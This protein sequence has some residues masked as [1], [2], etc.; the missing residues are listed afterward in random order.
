ME[1]R[2]DKPFD[3]A[4]FDLNLVRLLVAVYET[5]SVSRAALRLGITQP[6]ISYGLGRLRRQVGDALFIRSAS[7]MAP[8]PVAQALYR[9]FREALTAVESAI[10]GTLHFDFRSSTRTFRVAMSDVG[11]ICLVPPLLDH[12]AQVAPGVTLEV[13]Q[14]PVKDLL[15]EMASGR[16]DAAVGNLPVVHPSARSELLFPERYVCLL[17]SQ[18]PRIQGERL[19]LDQFLAE[20]HVVVASPF[21]VH[22][23]VDELLAERGARRRAALRIPHFTILPAII[24]HS[25]LLVTLPSALGEVFRGFAPVR[26]LELPVE[27]PHFEIRLLWHARQQTNPANVWLRQA[28]VATLQ[29]S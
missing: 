28:I 22:Q 9:Q 1:P 18:H 12:L 24:A 17:S 7:V 19:E 2:L 14:V 3:T 8:T 29:V 23:N 13:V 4:S 25:D 21:S 6:S 11:A 10:E 27:L 5:G 20:R 16:L 26:S 15:D